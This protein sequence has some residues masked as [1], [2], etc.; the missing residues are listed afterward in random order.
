MEW[1]TLTFFAMFWIKLWFLASVINE[2]WQPLPHIFLQFPISQ[3]HRYVQR[4]QNKRAESA[5]KKLPFYNV[6]NS[7]NDIQIS[8]WI[9]N[10]SRFVSWFTVYIFVLSSFISLCTQCRLH[11][12]IIIEIWN[13][14]P[15][16]PWLLDINQTASFHFHFQPRGSNK[17]SDNTTSI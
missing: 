15:I 9:Y 8:H 2:F 4:V 11:R 3:N 1:R 7:S 17:K 10:A 16:T 14:P 12:A 13:E 5:A 6:I